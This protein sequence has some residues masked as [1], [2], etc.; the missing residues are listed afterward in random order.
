[1]NRD[2]LYERLKELAEN[3]RVLNSQTLLNQIVGTN[4][5]V[6]FSWGLHQVCEV[7]D[8]FL[9]FRVTGRKFTGTIFV[10]LNGMD[11]YDLYFFSFVDAKGSVTEFKDLELNDIYGDQITELLDEIIET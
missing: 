10:G 11:L 1:M 2:E 5:F 4:P 9:S 6:P 7:S 8:R 3:K